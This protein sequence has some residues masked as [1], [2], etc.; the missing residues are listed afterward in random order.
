MHTQRQ[1]EQSPLIFHTSTTMEMRASYNRLPWGMKPA[2]NILSPIQAEIDGM[3]PCNIL[4]DPLEEES[5]ECAMSLN[6]HH[7]NLL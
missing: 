5:Q 6:S 4:K 7:Y 1:E 2:T 3:V